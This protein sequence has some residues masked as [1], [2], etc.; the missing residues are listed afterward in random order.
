MVFHHTVTNI[1]IRILYGRAYLCPSASILM[2]SLFCYRR[3]LGPGATDQMV[4]SISHEQQGL[5]KE[6]RSEA[7]L[8]RGLSESKSEF[9]RTL[10]HELRNP[11]TAVQGNN[12]MLVHKLTQFKRMTDQGAAVS[13]MLKFSSD[14]AHEIP[15]MLKMSSNAMKSAQH[16]ATVLNQTLTI[17]KM[18]ADQ[19]KVITTSD[20][21]DVRD[22]LETVMGM[23]EFTAVEKSIDLRLVL[24]SE[25]NGLW[26]VTNKNWLTQIVIN[27]L[28][29]A[30]KFTETG[31]VVIT[32]EILEAEGNTRLQ[33]SVADTG[34]GMSAAEQEKLFA[35]FSQA[36]DKIGERYGG[37]GLG[38][39]IVRNALTRLGG[40]IRV[41][42]DHDQGSVFSFELP[43]TI[44]ESPL[45]AAQGEVCDQRRAGPRVLVA[46]D[47]VVVQAVL[48]EQLQALGCRV[49][50]TSNG[51]EAVKEASKHKYDLIFTDIN[52]PVLG[53]L[54][55]TQA[56][57]SGVNSPLNAT[58]PIVG[59]SANSSENDPL[60]ADQAGMDAYITKPY[61]LAT[62]SDTV[63][64]FTDPSSPRLQET[65]NS[66]NSTKEPKRVLVVDD[67]RAIRAT[68]LEFVSLL[69]P[70]VVVD[71]AANGHEG[72]DAAAKT[73]Y[74]VI[75]MDMW[76]PGMDGMTATR[77]IRSAFKNAET[78][79]VCLSGN[80]HSD[81]TTEALRSGMTDFVAKPYALKDVERMLAVHGVVRSNRRRRRSN[82]SPRVLFR[83]GD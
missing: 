77:T 47:D 61:Q 56:I 43:C 55:A 12:E 24:P 26:V 78:P 29:N 1:I 19:G 54:E 72:V 82:E 60:L 10:C 7:A 38:L 73:R 11:L 22:A 62:L 15:R 5:L 41:E 25:E 63:K 57:R 37:S 21:V 35:P 44:T 14:F 16:M 58:T 69:A 31:S 45:T 66:A 76:M 75:F 33:V 79:I 3:Y 80:T 48:C 83:R 23:F 20:V 68:M 28:G 50:V 32:G 51:E 8:L 2:I 40:S 71:E 42:S 52:M 36:S 4:E 64:L 53:G 13:D 17:A 46:E 74:D 27:L 81:Q 39:D 49:T 67:D 59:L 34:I 18:E 70:D 9:M 65:P 30:L 6:S